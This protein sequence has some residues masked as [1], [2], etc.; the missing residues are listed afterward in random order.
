MKI[1]I[2]LPDGAS[3]TYDAGVTPSQ[4]AL[5]ISPRL[6]KDSI[7]A[8]VNG[9]LVDLTHKIESGGALALI[10]RQTPEGLEVIRHSTA[11]L[12]AHAIKE[13]YPDTQITIGPVTE[14]GF[15]Y[16]VDSTTQFAPE[17]L[18]KLETRMKEIAQ[19][20]LDVARKEMGRD[21][22][23]IFFKNQGEHYKAEII[24]S[25]P[26]SS[27]SL[28]TQGN[29]TDLCRGPHIPNTNRLGKFKL[30]T[31]AGAYWRGDEKNKM[32]QRIYGTAF[33]TQ[34]ELDEHLKILEELKKR[35][36]R[37]LA[38]EMELFSFSPFAPAMPFYLPA[39]TILHNTLIE[40]MRQ[41]MRSQGYDEVICPQIMNAELWKTSGHLEHYKNSMFFVNEDENT[42]IAL[43]PMNCPGHI[44]LYQG[45]RRSYRELPIR[46][47][48]FTKV[49]RNERGGATH[50]ILRVRNFSIDDG[51]IFCAEDQV[52]DE[53]SRV[54]KHT[55]RIYK[56]F[57]FNDAEIKIALRPEK[58]GGTIE[59]WNRAEAALEASLHTEGIAYKLLAG[60]G[61]FYGPKIEFHVRDSLKRLWQCGTVQLD[62]VMP[63]RFQ[64]AY[65]AADGSHKTPVMIHRAI[66]GSFERFIGVL[67]EHF[68]GHL[69]LWLC[70]NQV[71]IINVTGDQEKYAQELC[72][73][74]KAHNVRATA[75][76]RNE[77]LGYK[78]REAQLKKIPWMAV[79]G[80]KEVESKTVTLRKHTGENLEP[81]TFDQL[82]KFLE[83]KL[84][85]GGDTH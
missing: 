83:P 64:L 41:E 24:Q 80:N 28:Y 29:F 33:N 5:D 65:V 57:G 84:I 76:L 21:D 14:E 1:Q 37:R 68:A 34:K 58:F 61:A 25:I 7:A 10:T 63:E 23:I 12:L 62:F 71:T 22:A 8:K 31:I 44:I 13:L 51:H 30:L 72:A 48:E 67:I 50:G 60:E 16:D 55:Q 82:M 27:V 81:M 73:Q 47:G 36:H 18:E 19:R 32:L 40:F 49:H 54:L 9:K 2:T 6:E 79:V 59:N 66:L 38:P 52:G 17:H 56:A 70:P 53:I 74:L 26:E 78:I 4:I 43:K 35:D 42:S 45:S 39:G 85:T 20:N 3:R 75:D 46:F 11:H 69:P 15:Y 77:K